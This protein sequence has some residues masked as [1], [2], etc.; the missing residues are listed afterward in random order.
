M[1]YIITESQA[2]VM[3]LFQQTDEA[4][5]KLMWSMEHEDWV[6]MHCMYLKR[7]KS[8]FF[9]FISEKVIK[10]VYENNFGKPSDKW[11]KWFEIEWELKKYIEKNY[12][13]KIQSH[14]EDVC[15]K[16]SF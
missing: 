11:S 13:D 14:F 10:K 4:I 1:K 5:E 2:D 9:D 8:Y 15:S 7:R 3:E 6:E 16:Q 12:Q